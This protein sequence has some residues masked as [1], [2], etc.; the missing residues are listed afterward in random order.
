MTGPTFGMSGMSGGND[1]MGAR[2]MDWRHLELHVISEL[3]GTAIVNG[4][5]ATFQVTVTASHE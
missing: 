2:P 4:E 3:T 5:R 1:A